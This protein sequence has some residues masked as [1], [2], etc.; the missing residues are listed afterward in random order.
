M[1]P[2]VTLTAFGLGAAAIGFW[3]VARF[4]DFGPQGLPAALLTTAAISLLQ[5]PI[6]GLVAPAIAAIGIAGT[7]LAIILPSL[8]LLFW[9]SGCLVRSLVSLAA[10][11][12]R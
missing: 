2:T 7:L 3:A 5:T 1:D 9:A 12:S 10:P 4:P 11:H 8:L 6:L